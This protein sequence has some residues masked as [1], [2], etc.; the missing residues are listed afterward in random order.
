MT[1]HVCMSM[2][3]ATAVVTVQRVVSTL[4][5]ATL[6]HQPIV[7]MAHVCSQMSAATAVAIALWDV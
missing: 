5:R 6:I 2:N 4:Q 1:V 7:M 3:V